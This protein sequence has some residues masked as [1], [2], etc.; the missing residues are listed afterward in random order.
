MCRHC[1]SSSW[2]DFLKLWCPTKSSLQTSCKISLLGKSIATMATAFVRLSHSIAG[3]LSLSHCRTRPLF[4]NS[5]RRQNCSREIH[6]LFSLLDCSPTGCCSG[7]VEE[8]VNVRQ[9]VPPKF[10][11]RVECSA[12]RGS[13]LGGSAFYSTSVAEEEASGR[14]SFLCDLLQFICPYSFTSCPS[15]VTPWFT[16]NVMHFLHFYKTHFRNL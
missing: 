13:D 12:A 9:P 8:L 11:R 4:R 1:F 14:N 5:I 15:F 16:L 6:S 10:L 2:I 3:T 7:F